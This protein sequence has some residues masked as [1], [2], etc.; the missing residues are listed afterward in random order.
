MS[1]HNPLVRHVLC[2]TLE[3]VTAP[4]SSLWQVTELNRW[5]TWNNLALL[6]VLKEACLL[7]SASPKKPKDARHLCSPPEGGREENW[8]RQKPLNPQV[9]NTST[10]PPPQYSCTPRCC[11]MPQE[12]QRLEGFL[13]LLLSLE[14]RKGVL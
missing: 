2:T 13:Q 9:P 11:R 5:D 8:R 12:G 4:G 7:H 10:L 3:M 14:L 1:P 6:Q